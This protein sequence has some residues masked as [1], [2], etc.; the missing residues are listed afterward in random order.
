MTTEIIEFDS[1]INRQIDA[2][3]RINQIIDIDS[4]I[5]TTASMDST[6]GQ[7]FTKESAIELEEV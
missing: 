4:K 6:L 1:F 3:S 5:C 7:I 2:V